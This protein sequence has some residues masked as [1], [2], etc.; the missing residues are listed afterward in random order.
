MSL[1]QI[2]IPTVTGALKVV[3][4]QDEIVSAEFE[5]EGELSS[6]DIPPVLSQVRKAVDDY[7]RCKKELPILAMKLQGT[8]F[9]R[10]VWLELAKIPL[11]ETISYGELALRVGRPKAV[12]AVGQAVGRNPIPL[13]L[14]CHRVLGKRGALTGFSAGLHIKKLLLN[15]ELGTEY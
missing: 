4:D 12:R 7:F 1:S 11:G 2:I 5:S 8:A 6:R 9:Q 15:H 14:P 3:A 13:F 10:A